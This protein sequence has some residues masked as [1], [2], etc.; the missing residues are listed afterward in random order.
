MTQESKDV[1]VVSEFISHVIAQEVACSLLH[2]L[3]A[4]D[5]SYTLFYSIIKKSVHA[6][7]DNLQPI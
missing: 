3:G 5:E 1:K 7:Q 4:V 6:R 2:Y